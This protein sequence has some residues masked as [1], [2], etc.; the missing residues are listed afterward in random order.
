MSLGVV[1]S[2]FSVVARITI[3]HGIC[4]LV[5]RRNDHEKRSICL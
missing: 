1:C 5:L 4:V 3:I 2:L